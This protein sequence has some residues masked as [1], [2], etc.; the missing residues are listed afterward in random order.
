M[1]EN[2]LYEIQKTFPQYKI[3]EFIGKGNRGIAFS[4]HDDKVLKLT[5]D[6]KEFDLAYDLYS[7]NTSLDHYVTI[8]NCQEKAFYKDCTYHLIIEEELDTKTKKKEISQF[9]NRLKKVW[10][11]D[12]EI[13]KRLHRTYLTPDDIRDCC[14]YNKSEII[15]YAR[16]SFLDHPDLSV[17]YDHWWQGVEELT[18]FCNK[19]DEGKNSKYKHKFW[20]DINDGNLGYASNGLLKLLDQGE[21]YEEG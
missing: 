16:K 10:F 21:E 11:N 20:L 4:T 3:R 12:D 17:M 7:T 14:L 15:E 8:Y 1:D 18:A 6:I 5:L 13:S 19:L 9:I 2:D